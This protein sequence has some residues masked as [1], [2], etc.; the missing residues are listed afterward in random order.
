M[1]P[2]LLACGSNAASHLSINHPDDVSILT[3]TI[4]HPS[5]PSF[6]SESQILDLVSTSAHSLLLISPSSA[7][8]DRPGKNILLGAGTNTF[9]QLGPRCALWNDIKPESKWK[10]L[11]LLN[12][13][14]ID[15]KEE[16]EPVKIAATWTTSFIVYQ[17]SKSF[18][19]RQCE[20]SIG[21]S[22]LN[23]KIDPIEDQKIEQIVISCGSND[24]GELGSSS[25]FP[26]TLNAPSEIP[27][28]QASQKPTIVN[29]GLQP[30]ERIELIKGGQRHVIVVIVNGDGK[31]RVMGWGASRKGELDAKTLS[32]CLE[33]DSSSSSMFYSN[34]GKGKGKGKA[35]SRS[36]SSPPIAIDLP[37]SSKAKIVDISLGASH[38]LALLSDGTVMGWG[39]NLKNPITDVHTLRNIKSI[40]TTWNGSYFLN[41]QNEVFAQGSNTHSQ[42]LRLGCE[43]ISAKMGKIDIPLGWK[44]EK[45]VVGS[46]HLLLKLKREETGGE[47][48]WTGGWNEHGNL[49]LGD[50]NDRPS[51]ERVD[52]QGKIKG[53]WGGCASTWVWIDEQL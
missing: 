45:L 4:Y 10:P 25:N 34:K 31:Q 47:T 32:S 43:E 13:A 29:L 12:S 38:N 19:A 24:F 41:D 23:G 11:N 44:V 26:L 33:S 36:T 37:I 3:P 42:L 2:R 49:A 40:A 21:G 30:G 15:D 1:P 39:N 50:N 53:L 52:L 28:S 48:L 5:L 16:W 6:S 18:K 46:E 20:S 35:V 27:I 22:G 17:R 51:L 8:G 9:G 7:G 14:E